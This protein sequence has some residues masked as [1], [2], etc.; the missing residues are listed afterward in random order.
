M[1]GNKR[2]NLRLEQY[3]L[4]ELPE[5]EKNKIKLDKNNNDYIDNA[6]KDND[7]FFK[8][9]N[10]EKLVK[11]TENLVNNNTKTI[12]FPSKSITTLVAAACLIISINLLPDFSKNREIIYLKG[13]QKISIYLKDSNLVDKLKNMDKVYENNKLQITY[14]SQNSYGIIFSVDGLNNITFH[15]PETIYS[16]TKLDIGKEVTLPTSYTLDSAPYFEK[17]YLITSEKSFDA[18]IVREAAMDIKITNG[19]I[20]KDIE[21]PLKYNI[22]TMMLIKD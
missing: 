6:K 7:D 17:F 4:N 15:Y 5:K 20:D 22:D 9:F 14:R 1:A 11:D 18:N 21:L 8:K 12:K 19:R 13:S 3:I 16:S 2:F 10:V